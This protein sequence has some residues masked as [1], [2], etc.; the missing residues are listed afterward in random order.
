MNVNHR[1][2]VPDSLLESYNEHDPDEVEKVMSKEPK[3][4]ASYNS[5]ISEERS[6][7]SVQREVIEES[8]I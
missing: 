4:R 3:K 2:I 7:E 1:R 6:N 8:A 5:Q